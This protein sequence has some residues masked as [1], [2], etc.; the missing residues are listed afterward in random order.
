MNL[1]RP[2]KG[3]FQ[4]KSRL[5]TKE[6]KRL[7][8]LSERS[9]RGLAMQTA[10][11]MTCGVLKLKKREQRLV[12]PKLDSE[13]MRTSSPL[14]RTTNIVPKRTIKN[15][16]PLSRIRKSRYRIANSDSRV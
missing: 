4:K 13:I 2:S 16:K 12:P 9:T 14:L 11:V 10:E 3:R 5:Q 15:L 8:V 6:L 1:S 7:K